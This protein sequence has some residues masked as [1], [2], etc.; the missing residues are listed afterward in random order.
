MSVYASSRRGTTAKSWD[1]RTFVYWPALLECEDHFATRLYGE[2]RGVDGDV[3]AVEGVAELLVGVCRGRH[4]A[5]HQGDA[6][7]RLVRTAATDRE[8]SY[9]QGDEP[10]SSGPPE[11][12]LSLV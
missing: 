10:Q 6:G 7:G 11:H 5:R 4:L 9:D 8:D 3:V 12:S 1:P 2:S